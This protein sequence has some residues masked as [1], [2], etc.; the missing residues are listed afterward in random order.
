LF[1]LAPQPLQAEAARASRPGKGGAAV[2]QI[3][4]PAPGKKCNLALASFIG[5]RIEGGH[6]S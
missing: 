6:F 3:V 5:L 1:L 2:H 4:S